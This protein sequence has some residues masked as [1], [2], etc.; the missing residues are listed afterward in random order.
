MHDENPFETRCNINTNNRNLLD[1]NTMDATQTIN[2]SDLVSALVKPG[3][4]ILSEM[5]PAKC[6]LMHMALGVEGEAGELGDAIKKHVI[7]NQLLDMDNVEEE[8]GDIEW[9]LEA[10]RQFTGITREQCIVA[11]I[12]KLAKRYE[13]GYSNRAAQERADKV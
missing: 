3:H 9:F 4:E 10:L 8:M 6:Y 12:K 7:Y 11:N 1:F 2:H 5:T 13:K